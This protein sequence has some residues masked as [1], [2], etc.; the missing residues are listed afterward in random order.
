[1][2]GGAERS[3]VS[4]YEREKEKVN[5]LLRIPGETEILPL[6]LKIRCSVF[7]KPASFSRKEIP[8]KIYTKWFDY[9]KIENTLELRTRRQK[10]VIQIHKDGTHK[11]INRLL[12]DKKVPKQVRDFCLLLACDNEILWVLGLRSSEKYYVTE[13]TKRL[14]IANLELCGQRDSF[15]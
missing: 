3:A 13:N 5:K 15:K 8:E 2:L 9:D 14:L 10:D 11:T 4:H 6:R 1:M 12:I 7:L